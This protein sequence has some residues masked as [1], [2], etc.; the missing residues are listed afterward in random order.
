MGTHQ[1]DQEDKISRDRDGRTHI[2]ACA[3]G[4]MP[5]VGKELY[6]EVHHVLCISCL[7]DG[8]ISGF[9]PDKAQLKMLITAL[10]ATDWDINAE[11]NLIALPKKTVYVDQ[12]RAPAGWDDCCCHQIDHNNAEGYRPAVSKHLD[13]TIWNPQK[14]AA[15]ACKYDPVTFKDQLEKASKKWRDFL[16]KRGSGGDSAGKNVAYCWKHQLEMPDSWYVPFS[17][18]PEPSPRKPMNPEMTGSIA[19]RYKKFFQVHEA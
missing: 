6:C 9:V 4:Y 18:A 2:D 11:P 7:S 8:T 15:K 16:V 19:A 3:K 5:G 10:K 12:K 17:M 1:E 14:K 13:K